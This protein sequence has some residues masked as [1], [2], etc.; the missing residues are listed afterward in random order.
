[1]AYIVISLCYSGNMQSIQA[2]LKPYCGDSSAFKLTA[3][4]IMP[5]LLSSKGV[6]PYVTSTW[7]L[8]ESCCCPF[9]GVFHWKPAWGVTVATVTGS[10]ER[11]GE[12][13]GV[14]QWVARREKR[15][16][17]L[18]IIL[19]TVRSRGNDLPS[20]ARCAMSTV[21]WF[22]PPK[23]RF[24]WHISDPT[25]K[26]VGFKFMRTKLKCMGKTEVAGD[27]CMSGTNG[28]E[29]AYSKAAWAT[30]PRPPQKTE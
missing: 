23:T 19:S 4:S 25:V 12:E 13:R 16:A 9:S 3:E 6:F 15:P 17:P 29:H 28:V 11:E 5:F 21:Q 24:R 26:I 1:M 30:C 14:R 22:F 20:K 18:S 8:Q 27:V 7:E 2:A 10:D